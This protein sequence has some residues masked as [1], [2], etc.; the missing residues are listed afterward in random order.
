MRRTCGRCGHTWL[1]APAD[2]AKAQG[3]RQGADPGSGDA[4]DAQAPESPSGAFSD[5][6]P[7]HSSPE[8]PEDAHS[9]AKASAQASAAGFSP[10]AA[11]GATEPP[12]S[13]HEADEEER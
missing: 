1:E 9:D 8:R 10:N 4:V 7:G 13:R 12:E 11:Q 2:A 6:L 3:G 5:G